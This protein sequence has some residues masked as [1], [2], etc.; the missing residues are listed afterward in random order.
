MAACKACCE[1]TA[2]MRFLGT[3]TTR[4]AR[5]RGR[6]G[7][8]LGDVCKEQVSAVPDARF[9]SAPYFALDR[10]ARDVATRPDGAPLLAAIEIPLPAV[11]VTGVGIDAAGVA[12][13]HARRA[14]P[15]SSR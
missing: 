7:A 15:P 3:S 1:P 12:A 6:R 10:I 13:D 2:K 4:A 11:T 8:M 9:M 5:S 14:G